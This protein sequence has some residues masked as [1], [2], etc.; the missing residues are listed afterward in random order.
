MDMRTPEASSYQPEQTRSAELTT[1]KKRKLGEA[2]LA[3][4]SQT[5]PSSEAPI[6]AKALTPED[7]ER[8]YAEQLTADIARWRNR[9][10]EDERD[11][12]RYAERVHP[13]T[14]EEKARYRNRLLRAEHDAEFSWQQLQG[15]T[16][17]ALDE[18]AISSDQYAIAYAQRYGEGVDPGKTIEA[19]SAE[20]YDERTR[21]LQDAI[22]NNPTLTPE[23]RQ[24]QVRLLRHTWSVVYAYIE[25]T[26][27]IYH[28]HSS[29]LRRNQRHND[30]IKHLNKLNDLARENH[31]PPLTF[32]N[33]M[34]NDVT[35]GY[36]ER[37]DKGGALWHKTEYEREIVANYFRKVFAK[38]IA[39][40]DAAKAARA[41]LMR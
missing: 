1:A 25:S 27:D 24:T 35:F 12:I 31:V 5:Q 11:F 26:D 18:H 30:M 10:D 33:F 32:R 20:L 4:A 13:Q 39:R 41:R 40:E 3:T 2:A 6:A 15:S 17:D 9:Y 8:A 28:D 19:A 14:P 37:R 36:Q 16:R 23:D 22:E 29:Q 38:E 34:P 21:V 7:E